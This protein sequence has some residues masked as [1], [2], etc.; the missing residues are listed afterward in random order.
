MRRTIIEA[1]SIG[2]SASGA[3]NEAE[4]VLV[5]TEGTVAL[6]EVGGADYSDCVLDR[7][8]SVWEEAKLR[9][10]AFRATGNEP[11]WH[12]EIMP[13]ESFESTVTATLDGH[14]YRGFGRA[15]H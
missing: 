14:E 5:W 1:V 2:R 3:R 13:G 9:G 11:G 10:I 8:A 4:D 12:L 15:L 7:R 6:L